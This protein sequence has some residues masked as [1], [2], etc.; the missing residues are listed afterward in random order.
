LGPKK[1]E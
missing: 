1:T